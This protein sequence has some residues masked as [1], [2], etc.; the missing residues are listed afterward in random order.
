MGTFLP[1][2]PKTRNNYTVYLP[3]SLLEDDVKV[4]EILFKM[5]P[6]LPKCVLCNVE[7]NPEKNKG[8]MCKHAGSWHAQYSDCGILKCGTNLLVK[9]SIGNQHWSCC[10]TTNQFSDICP[11][12]KPHK[13]SID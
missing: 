10:Y 5:P 9:G 12:S 4:Q 2:V 6:P 3:T 8:G 1:C 11:S 7:F 13:I